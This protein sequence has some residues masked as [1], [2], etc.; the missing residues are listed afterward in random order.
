[1]QLLI[2]L[3]NNLADMKALRSQLINNG[4]KKYVAIPWDD[5]SNGSK[6]TVLHGPSTWL[7]SLCTFLRETILK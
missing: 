6:D 4:F 3:A 5:H 2:R 1:M 7:Y